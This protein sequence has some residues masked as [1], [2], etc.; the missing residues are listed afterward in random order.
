MSYTIGVV[1]SPVMD[2]LF[3]VHAS[4]KAGRGQVEINAPVDKLAGHAIDNAVYCAREYLATRWDA[5]PNWQKLDLR[6]RF[7]TPFPIA[8]PSLG[9][10]VACAVVN[11]F[12]KR[13][14]YPT[15]M[16]GV[17]TPGGALNPVNDVERKVAVCLA[18]GFKHFIMPASNVYFMPPL[19]IHQ[20][21]RAEEVF[22]QVIA[23]DGNAEHKKDVHPDAGVSDS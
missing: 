21:S 5:D 13:P 20:A 17:I 3:Q 4:W 12:F 19:T 8:G 9:L 2:F 10:A 15:P 16:T 7:K 23:Y 14:S 11:S 18:A 6:I 1:T 22:E